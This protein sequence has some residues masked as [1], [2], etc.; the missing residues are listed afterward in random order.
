[1]SVSDQRHSLDLCERLRFD[2]HTEPDLLRAALLH[3]VG[4]AAGSLPLLAR[5]AYSLVVMTS[6]GIADWLCGS[7]TG[8]R[9][10]FY[11]AAHHPEIGAA[12]AARA[13]ASSRVVDLI[14]GHS[15]PGSDSLSRILYTY[16]RGM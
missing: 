5:V 4:K 11:L 7:P 3:D 9:S 16:D 15:D 12:A 13:G 1:M 10:A 2:G 6:P 8:W 14:A